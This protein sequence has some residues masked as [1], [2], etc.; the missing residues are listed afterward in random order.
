MGQTALLAP[1]E[2]HIRDGE[3]SQAAGMDDYLAKTVTP[4]RRAAVVERWRT[5]RGCEDRVADERDVLDTQVL[6]TLQERAAQFDDEDR[7]RMFLANVPAHLWL[8]HLWEDCPSRQ[9]G[10]DADAIPPRVAVGRWHHVAGDPGASRGRT[11]S[12]APIRGRPRARRR[13]AS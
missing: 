11:A 12:L 7:R 1:E 3:V 6:A 5:G 13:P 4:E 10:G 9:H 8:R 2:A